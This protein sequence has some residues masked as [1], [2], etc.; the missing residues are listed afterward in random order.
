MKVSKQG[1]EFIASHEGFEPNI[2]KDIAGIPTI[3]YGH[4]ILPHEFGIF[5]GGITQ[6]EALDLLID[7]AEKHAKSVRASV[8]VELTQRQFDALTSLAFNIGNGAFA[9]STLVKR[10]NA[11]EE[12]PAIEE[13]WGWWNK[14]TING[15]KQAVKGLT[16]RREAEVK[17]FYSDEQKKK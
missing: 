7:D 2:Y 3:G 11:G 1:A 10:I 15:T 9:S 6:A 16:N 4:V 14:A 17:Y 5:G 13:A 8:N 12:R